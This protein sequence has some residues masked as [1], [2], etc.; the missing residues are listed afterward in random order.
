MV[1]CSFLATSTTFATIS[2]IPGVGHRGT[3]PSTDDTAAPSPPLLSVCRHVGS[4][5]DANSE[6]LTIRLFS[7]RAPEQIFDL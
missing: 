3:N 2:S 6:L 7:L 4:N 1:W 5:S